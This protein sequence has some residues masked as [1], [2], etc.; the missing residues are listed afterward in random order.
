M[1]VSKS[2]CHSEPVLS[3]AWE[4]PKQKRKSSKNGLK[5]LEI[6]TPACGL[7]RNDVFF[8]S[9]DNAPLLGCVAFTPLPRLYKWIPVHSLLA[10]LRNPGN[11]PRP[12]NSPPDCFLY[13]L[14]IPI[15]SKR[16]RTPVGVRC[17]LERVMGI[18]PTS[19]PWEGR[20]LPMN[21]TRLLQP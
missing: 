7:V 15:I 16:Q 8:D 19:Q 11:L 14:S 17:L 9:L 21:Y 2:I 6:A 20:I 10:A 5:C 4:S 18:E 3:L 1:S 13:G 12:K